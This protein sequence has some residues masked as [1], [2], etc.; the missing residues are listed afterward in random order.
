VLAAAAA[1]LGGAATPPVP[2]PAAPISQALPPQSDVNPVQS[3]PN[4]DAIASGLASATHD[5]TP[6]EKE[7][8]EGILRIALHEVWSEFESVMKDIGHDALK[9]LVKT[10]LS[11]LVITGV[12][13]PL[14]RILRRHLDNPTASETEKRLEAKQSVESLRAPGTDGPTD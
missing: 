9:E 13:R 2:V 14:R 12:L 6:Q 11:M 3:D 1:V 4:V 5:A 7:E 8:A 10:G